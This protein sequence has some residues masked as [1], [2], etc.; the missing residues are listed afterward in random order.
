MVCCT[1][2]HS[3]NPDHTSGNWLP[4]PDAEPVE[5]GNTFITGKEKERIYDTFP[6]KLLF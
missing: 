1:H 2:I 6:F 5:C 4:D 3:K